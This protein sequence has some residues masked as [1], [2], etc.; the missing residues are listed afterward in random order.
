MTNQNKKRRSK[1][2]RDST[3]K[4]SLISINSA[5]VR[6]TESPPWLVGVFKAQRRSGF[7]TDTIKNC[8][9]E[10]FMGYDF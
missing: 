4:P 7:P 6:A 9:V 5:G 10:A 3:L 1:P 8:I 2:L